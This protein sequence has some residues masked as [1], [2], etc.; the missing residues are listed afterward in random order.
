[1]VTIRLS[2]PP[3][4]QDSLRQPRSV[5]R[6]R[7]PMMWPAITDGRILVDPWRKLGKTRPILCRGI[8]GDWI[9]TALGDFTAKGLKAS[10]SGGLSMKHWGLTNRKWRM[11]G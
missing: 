9:P 8:G 11:I 2:P 10:K 1:M 6:E 3:V 7:A 5:L 4:S